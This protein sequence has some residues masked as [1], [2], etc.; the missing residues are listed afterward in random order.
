MIYPRG[1]ETLVTPEHLEIA[2]VIYAA[3]P[4]VMAS[5]TT[6]FGAS[7]GR[8]FDWDSAPAFYQH[9]MLDLADAVVK[10]LSAK[11]IGK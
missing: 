4:F 10:H 9:D 1:K 5:T 2:Q 6:T 7:I 3:R 8:V 11:R